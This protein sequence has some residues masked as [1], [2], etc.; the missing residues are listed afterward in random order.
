MESAA[1]EGFPT[2]RGTARRGALELHFVGG[3]L[4]NMAAEGTRPFT[5]DGVAWP[6]VEHYFQAHKHPGA[7]GA[8]RVREIRAAPT[9]SEAKRR[10]Y[11]AGGSFAAHAER[12]EAVKV[13]VMYTGLRG[14]FT[15]H[16]DMRGWLLA[17]RG[18]SIVEHC[19][20]AVWGDGAPSFATEQRGAGSNLFGLCLTALRL[21]LQGAAVC[22]EDRRLLEGSEELRR[23]REE[24]LAPQLLAMEGG[25]R[26]VVAD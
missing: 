7:E 23:F 12:W 10:S 6:S 1:A 2:G 21:E 20:D 17:T 19:R 4:D 14:K 16:E 5:L 25:E 13:A 24:V 18:L 22:A 8:A 3:W 11:A 15:Q 26:I 9:P